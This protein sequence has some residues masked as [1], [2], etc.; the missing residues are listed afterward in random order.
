[1]RQHSAVEHNAAA[2]V[3]LSVF[4]LAS[5]MQFEGLLLKSLRTLTKYQPSV[6]NRFIENKLK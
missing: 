5:P 1:M 6:I 2:I 3:F 4:S